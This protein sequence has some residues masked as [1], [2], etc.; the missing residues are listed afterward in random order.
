MNVNDVFNSVGRGST[1]LVPR[2]EVEGITK[3]FQQIV[4]SSQSKLL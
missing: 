4:V 3:G 2:T 1:N